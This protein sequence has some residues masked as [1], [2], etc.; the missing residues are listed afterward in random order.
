M[1]LPDSNEAFLII[2]PTYNHISYG[3]EPPRLMECPLL[4]EQTLSAEPESS[5]EHLLIVLS[6]TGAFTFL[7]ATE[8]F[9]SL[10]LE[11]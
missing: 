8:K 10:E 4:P 6:V 2:A 7:E 1:R 3:T 9:V 5:S 11:D